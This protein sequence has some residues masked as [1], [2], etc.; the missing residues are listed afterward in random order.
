MKTKHI[1]ET[2]RQHIIDNYT[3]GTST[4]ELGREFDVN[5]G[6]IYMFLR[7]NCGVKMR[8]KPKCEDYEE[9][10]L[11]LYGQGRT[12]YAIAKELGLNNSTCQR[13]CKKLGFDFSQNKKQ[14]D[15]PL[16]DSFDAILKDYMDG[17]GCYRLSKK[18]NCSESSITRLLRLNDVDVLHQKKYDIP[19]DFFDIIDTEQKAYILG[20]FTADGHNAKNNTFQI[21]IADPCILS[22][23]KDAMKYNGPIYE[24]Q[25][26]NPN[27]QK[28]H[29]LNIHSKQISTR[30]TELGYPNQ[31]TFITQMPSEQDLPIH[32]RHHYIRG[33]FDGDGS[34][35]TMGQNC[36]AF[37][38]AGSE[39]LL[40]DMANFIMLELDI[41][42]KIYKHKTIYILRVTRKADLPKVAIWLYN[43][44]TIWLKR[45][46]EK[47]QKLVYNTVV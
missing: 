46:R 30:L 31:K 8:E 18:Y 7:D 36:V 33:I 11:R 41:S 17:M 10:L 15:V 20:F 9:D 19:H 13:Y 3:S 1:L 12:C 44:A 35:H 42:C 38:I 28:R 27:H 16:K 14:R 32:L 21:T 34:I 2:N 23:I 47:M 29:T 5:G 24:Y 25:P 22:D 4:C 43:D 45:K 6:S 26:P 37:T 40:N 39:K